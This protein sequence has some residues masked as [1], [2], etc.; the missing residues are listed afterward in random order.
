MFTDGVKWIEEKTGI[1]V[2]GVLPYVQDHMIDSEDSLSIHEYRRK[3]KTGDLDVAVMTLPYSSNI[4]DIEPFF[5]EED[6][7]LRFVQN[8]SQFG[9]PDVVIIPGTKSTI[10]DLQF[11]KGNGLADQIISHARNGG[12]VTGI[13][14]GYQMLGSKLIDE[15]G[16]DMGVPLFEENGLG[17]IDALTYFKKEKQTIRVKGTYQSLT[18]T[19]EG[20][21]EGY[22]IHLGD[23]I[24]PESSAKRPLFLFDGDRE[25]GYR[26]KD[27]RLIG[28]YLHHLFHNDGFRH[29][30]L[31]AVRRAV[32]LPQRPRVDVG[33]LKDKRYD[34]LA[35]K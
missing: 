18:G 16:T 29:D 4:S 15:E 6:V 13:C 25:E 27:G 26:S 32:N 2:L 11:L 31:N 33:S 20:I 34:R 7:C 23:T 10:S 24:Y 9:R 35:N 22:E 5:Y 28:T 1:P 12:F 19:E 3:K 21:V 14:G 8:A 17:L 30:W